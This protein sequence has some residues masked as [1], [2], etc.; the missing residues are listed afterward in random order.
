MG[1]MKNK[2]V[3][4]SDYREIRKRQALSGMESSA[5]KNGESFYFSFC[6]YMYYF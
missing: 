3:E 4:R 2:G 5:R 1:I 6:D